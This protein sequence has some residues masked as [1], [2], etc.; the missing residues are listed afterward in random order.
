M[1]EGEGITKDDAPSNPEE[2]YANDRTLPSSRARNRIALA[3]SDAQ[4]TWVNRHHL[5]DS[6]SVALA[7]QMTKRPGAFRETGAITEG[8]RDRRALR[9]YSAARVPGLVADD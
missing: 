6:I 8:K 1:A 7:G 3:S 2:A 4:T 9:P 5:G